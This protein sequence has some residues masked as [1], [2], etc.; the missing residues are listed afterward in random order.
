MIISFTSKVP[1]NLTQFNR[2]V[3]S[4][5][6][7]ANIEVE[8]HVKMSAQW[9]PPWPKY[10]TKMIKKIVVDRP[11]WEG[12]AAQDL[13]QSFPYWHP[14]EKFPNTRQAAVHQQIRGPCYVFRIGSTSYKPNITQ[15][16]I[17]YRCSNMF[18]EQLYCFSADLAQRCQK[19]NSHTVQLLV[20]LCT[21][22]IERKRKCIGGHYACLLPAKI[23]PPCSNKNCKCYME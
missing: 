4:W 22:K 11:N 8:H 18:Q 13:L 2:V 9:W 16:F 3:R 21:S 19:A 20:W 12:R 15:Y 10:E 7:K 23:R 5:E 14:G 6:L 1:T 17:N